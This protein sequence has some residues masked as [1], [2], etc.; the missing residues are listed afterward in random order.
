VTLRGDRIA[1]FEAISATSAAENGGGLMKKRLMLAIAV[2]V[3]AAACS[4]AE[5][6]DAGA[7][8]APAAIAVATPAS[9]APD[10][11][12]CSLLSRAEVEAVF[13]EL[14]AEPRGNRG[15]RNEREC[16]FSNTNGQWLELSVYGTDRWGL[17]KGTV[18]EQHPAA[19][20]N[21]GEEAFSV[22]QG[23]ETDLY[24]RSRGAVL[25]TSG[26]CSLETITTLAAKA[27]ARLEA[28]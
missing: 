16:R 2:I 15:L 6:T 20:P 9:H 12:P 4:R 25:Q 17:E 3:L 23:T 21:L 26:S 27:A 1:V 14:K 22:R 24:I 5:R 28:K 8:T 13:G 18:S 7:V 11:D 10:I 19:I